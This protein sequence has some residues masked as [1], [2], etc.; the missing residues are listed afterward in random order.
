[1]PSF[2]CQLLMDERVM[3]SVTSCTRDSAREWLTLA[4]AVPLEPRAQTYQLAD[5]NRAL[6][7]MRDGRLLGAAVLTL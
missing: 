1:I 2:P 3:R 7:D 5:V 4:A 6:A